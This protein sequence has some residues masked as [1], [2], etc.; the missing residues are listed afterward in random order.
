MSVNEDLA[1]VYVM[2]Y[3]HLGIILWQLDALK[4]VLDQE[5]ER[6]ERHPTFK[7]GWDHEA[8]TYDYLAEHAP[9][10][11][12]RMKETL[13]RFRGRL[14][15]GTC[16]YGQPLSQFI[17]EES[18][19]RQLTMALE[20][21]EERLGVSLSVYIMS[22]HAMHSQ[23]PQLLI[24]CGFRGAILR[25]HFMMYGY[26]P[27]VEAPV[28][29]WVGLDGSHIPAV[30]TYPGQ[31]EPV[32]RSH[33]QPFGAVTLDN[34]ILTDYPD[35]PQTLE[36]F[37]RRYGQRIRP[38]VAS[39]VD[40]P[41]QHE[42]IIAAHEEDPAYIWV[43]AEEVFS[44]LPQPRL[45][46]RTTPNDFGVRMPWGFCGNWIWNQIRR[47]EAS[48]LIAERLAA[49]GHALGKADYEADLR[50]AWKSLLVGQHHDIQIVGLESD[51]HTHLDASIAQ[52]SQIIEKVMRTLARRV[53]ASRERRWVV[54]NPVPWKRM[55]W[56]ATRDGAGFVAEIPGL[57]FA[58]FPVL[59]RAENDAAQVEW[60]PRE[61]RLRTVHY[62]L[63][64]GDRSGFAALLD[65]QTGRHLLLPGRP[66]GTL[67]ALIDG[68]PCE[69]Q[70]TTDVRPEGE[71]ALVQESGAVGPLTYR[72]EWVFYATLSRID[73]H[74]ELEAHGELI[75]R[76]SQDI[77]DPYSAF[78]HEY[79]LRLRFYPAIRADAVGVRDLPFAIAETMGRCVEGNYWTAISDGNV[80]LAL[81]NRGLMGSF[82][83]ADGAFSVPLA[84][85]MYYVWDHW[86]GLVTK[87]AVGPGSHF[88]KGTYR[89]ELGVMPFLGDWQRADVHRRAIEYNL[90]CVTVEADELVKPLGPAWVPLQIEGSGAI[91]SALYTRGGRTYARFYEYWGR[92][93]AISLRWMGRPLDLV[94]VDLRERPLGALGQTLH[95]G[96]W[97][98]RTVELRGI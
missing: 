32:I 79:K 71:R 31:E 74:C 18:N 48:V 10:L 95:L 54:F 45:D 8:Y 55:D 86:D 73:W 51:A 91:L 29:W 78:E 27:T 52:S 40:D 14:G 23:M 39:R 70:G 96:P 72:A 22:E 90:P 59:S 26:N 16:T 35:Y 53:G 76:P 58:A 68:V 9:E 25:T 1:S 75:G 5:I 84:F 24:G 37:R 42:E 92:E 87:Q 4:R 34:R 17:N 64:L 56:V 63:L 93:A 85:S 28:V 80:G 57:G 49:L 7:L 43:L 83:E 81:F 88:M 41:R 82:R 89:Y 3:D 2:T 20:T 44:H 67:A 98:V 36:A 12:V 21:V 15:V 69:S 46:F 11:L 66:N 38:L 61:R 77:H 13:A 30:P 97:Q 47:A 94:E 50:V 62:D 60:N 33:A 19:V 65:R 6:L